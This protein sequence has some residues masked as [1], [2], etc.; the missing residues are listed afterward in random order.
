MVNV[1]LNTSIIY[2]SGASM[3][4]L[5]MFILIC[6]YWWLCWWFDEGHMI[7]RNLCINLDCIKMHIGFF[8]YV[9]GSR[10]GT[11]NTYHRASSILSAVPPP[12]LL[13][14]HGWPKT[15]N[16]NEGALY[17]HITVRFW[18]GGQESDGRRN[19][20]QRTIGIPAENG[21]FSS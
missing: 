3:G 8:K 5:Y 10:T 18:H 1:V 6:R 9:W 7:S 14:P 20:G 17:T 15:T 13:G 19:D 16:Q 2:V 12:S 21:G 11:L 4:K